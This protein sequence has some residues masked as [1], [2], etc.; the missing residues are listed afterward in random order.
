MIIQIKNSYHNTVETVNANS[1]KEAEQNYIGGLEVTAHNLTDKEIEE[2]WE[3][4][5]NSYGRA[6]NAT[7]DGILEQL[8]SEVSFEVIK[9]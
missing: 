8:I 4:Y 7:Y 5:Y 3:K 2:D 9:N 6:F 1:L